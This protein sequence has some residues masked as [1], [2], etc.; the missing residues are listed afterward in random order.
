MHS[1]DISSLAQFLKYFV[2]LNEFE[3]HFS[4]FPIFVAGLRTLVST[5]FTDFSRGAILAKVE[6]I[7]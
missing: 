7:N 3:N 2:F 4:D 5:R 6:D 1:S